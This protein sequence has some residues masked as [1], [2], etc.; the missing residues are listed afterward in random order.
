MSKK[1]FKKVNKYNFG[2]FMEKNGGAVAGALGTAADLASSIQDAARGNQEAIN[3]TQQGINQVNNTT[4]NAGNTSSLMS[5][6]SAANYMDPVEAKQFRSDKGALKEILGGAAKGASAGVSFGGPWGAAIGGVAGALSGTAAWLTGKSKGKREADKANKQITAANERMDNNFQNAVQEL[7]EAQI[8]NA[9]ANYAAYGGMLDINNEYK[10]GG[11]IHIKK[12]NRGKF[13]DYCGGKVTE[14]CIKK[15]KNSSSPAVRKRATFAANARKWKHADGGPLESNGIIWPSE[16][17]FINNGGTHE[18]NP[19]EGIQI[20]VDNEG[21]PNLVEEG[22]VIY[23]DYVFSNRLKVPKEVRKELKLG[24]KDITFADAVEKFAKESEER[25]ND[26]ISELGLRA[27]LDKLIPVQERM[28]NNKRNNNS[29]IFDEGGTVVINGK[30]LDKNRL[31]DE[32]YIGS[33]DRETQDYIRNTFTIKPDG[34]FVRKPVGNEIKPIESILNNSYLDKARTS[35]EKTYSDFISNG[36]SLTRSTTDSTS[37]N[38]N[39]SSWTSLLRY[40]PVVGNALGLL[41]N[42]ADYSN[43]DLI[44]RSIDSLPTIGYTPIGNYLTYNP[45]DINYM[46]NKLATQSA[47]TRRNIL[48]TSAGNRGLANASLLAA[49]LNAQTALG[50]AYKQTL[51]YNQAQKQQV[52]AF[53]RG[54]NQFNTE[55]GFRADTANADIAKTKLSARMQEANLREQI[56]QSVAASR[57]ANA[58]G[59]FN[60]LGNIGIDALNRADRDMLINAGVFGTLSQKPSGWTNKKWEAYQNFANISACGGN[61]N[62]KRTKRK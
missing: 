14:E 45:M 57:S 11:G 9:L 4:F 26:R 36:R 37:G 47:A 32:S 5:Q 30:T 42:K 3:A 23:G 10:M 54:T 21:V 39:K 17:M 58:S 15:G 18:E 52:E 34:S 2:S 29:N 19:N 62:R 20:G 33:L 55:L 22:E 53:N 56:A 49:D 40:A 6:W 60:S 41:S 46:S 48:N 44:S 51:E 13:T 31:N 1:V 50:D 28:R 7:Q 16:L 27:N 12:E 43:A 61:I 24:K 35:I 25:P 59:L 8:N 38:D